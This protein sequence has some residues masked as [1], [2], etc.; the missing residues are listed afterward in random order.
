AF[1]GGGKKE[2]WQNYAGSSYA[3]NYSYA[4][5]VLEATNGNRTLVR[6]KN[7]FSEGSGYEAISPG[8][9]G[10]S[11]SIKAIFD[12]SGRRVAEAVHP[13]EKVEIV[14]DRTFEQHDLLRKKAT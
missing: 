8:K 11:F 6:T 13:N 4:G 10:E 9:L 12:S 7:R 5:E 2:N 14:A 1:F 3:R